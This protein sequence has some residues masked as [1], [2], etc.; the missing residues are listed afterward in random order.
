MQ[1]I[2]AKNVGN[3]P[4]RNGKPEILIFNSS[5]L[6]NI[7][8]EMLGRISAMKLF[9]RMAFTVEMITMNRVF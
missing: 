7:S 5:S 8:L 9:K 1:G 2:K 6:A 4:V 3:P